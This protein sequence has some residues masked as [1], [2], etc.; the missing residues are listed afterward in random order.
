MTRSLGEV[1]FGVVGRKGH[2]ALRRAPTVE[3]WLAYGHVV[4]RFGNEQSNSIE[5]E[6]SRQHLRRRIALEV[7]SFLAGLLRCRP[8]TC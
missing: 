2:P 1:Q 5:L 7:P 4:T 3:Q 8:R 6:L